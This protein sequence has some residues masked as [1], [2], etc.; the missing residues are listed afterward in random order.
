MGI[1]REQD[2]I[3]EQDID[4][5]V[6]KDAFAINNLNTYQNINFKDR[7]GNGW[8]INTGISFSTNKDDITNE[9]QDAGNRKVTISTPVFYSFKNFS[10]LNLARYAQARVVLEK[11][12][13]GLT[14]VRFGGDYFYINEKTTY[15][16]HNGSSFDEKVVDH[17]YAAFAETDIYVTNDLAAKVGTRLEHS[18]IM[19]KW[20][21]AP[22]F[23]WHIVGG[24]QPG[25]FCLWH[26]LPK[27]REKIASGGEWYRL[28]KGNALYFTIQQ[29]NKRLHPA[30]RIVL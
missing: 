5:V 19:N 28:F 13:R 25:V 20:N 1:W 2:G 9:V 6:L 12:I 29:A 17:L 8:K 11:K 16:L 22:G 18:A 15:T 4:S 24:Q 26:F 7:I 27:S 30:G 14:A 10:L 23:H 21:L 3:Q